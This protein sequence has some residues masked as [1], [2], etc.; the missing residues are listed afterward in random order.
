MFIK[1][2]L[3]SIALMIIFLYAFLVRSNTG[4]CVFAIVGVVLSIVCVKEFSVLLKKI[5]LHVYRGVSEAFACLFFLGI[6][7]DKKIDYSTDIGLFIL[8]LFAIY[9]WLKVLYSKQK[10]E[11][12]YNCAASALTVAAVI[13]PLNCLTLIYMANYSVNYIGMNLALFLILVTKF[14]DIGAYCV[15]TLTSRRAAGNHKIVPNISPKKSW[16]GAIGGMIISV[17]IAY[18]LVELLGLKFGSNTILF[19]GIIGVLLFIGGFIGDLSESVLKRMT[20]IKDSGSII[21]GI[22]GALD[23]ADS[24]FINA[25]LFYL[26]LKLFQIV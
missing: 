8:A 19:T 14:G 25:P 15:G 3:S 26:F 17:I 18:L 13:I 4:L 1:R 6:I 22:G 23:L 2:F 21:P 12:I 5:D 10:K 7:L 20:G 16:E 11:I 9:C 24:L